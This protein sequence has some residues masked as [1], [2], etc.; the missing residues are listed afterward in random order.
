MIIFCAFASLRSVSVGNDTIEYHR[1]FEVVGGA[2]S[3]NDAFEAS[4]YE[5]GYVVL[6]YVVSRYTDNFNVLLFITSVFSYGATMFFIHKYAR[7]NSLAILLA[8]GMSVFYDMMLAARQGVAMG[9][10]Y[11]AFPV[12]LGRKPVRYFL[13]ILLA[14]Q[15]HTSAFLLLAA[16]FIPALKLSTFGGWLKWGALIG[17]SI[18]SLNWILSSV[19]AFSPYYSHYLNSEY[20]QG[21]VRI[22]TIIGVAVRLLM[23]LL[24][25]TCG[26]NGTGETESDE[27]DRKLLAFVIADVAILIVSLGFN[28]LD[29]FEMYLGLPFAVGLANIVARERGP[30]NSYVSALLILVAFAHMTIFLLYRPEWYTLF[31]YRTILSGG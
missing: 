31:P 9:I 2:N 16:Y 11:L 8:F 1:V 25:A 24:A 20:A 4:R 19:S 6:N 18:F 26:L 5:R 15:F 13:L 7:S 12:L 28:L 17:S 29:R 23:V 22:A 10:V 3:L 27:R 21:G 30:R 14:S